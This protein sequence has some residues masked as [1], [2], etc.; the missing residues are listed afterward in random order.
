M[1]ESE[2]ESVHRPRIYIFQADSEHIPLLVIEG[3]NAVLGD[4]LVAGGYIDDRAAQ[5][6]SQTSGHR[7][8]EVSGRWGPQDIQRDRRSL[9]INSDLLH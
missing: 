9:G 4:H 2:G 3:F 8:L 6:L 1:R 7:A 5:L